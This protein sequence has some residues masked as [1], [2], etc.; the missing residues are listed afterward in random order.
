MKRIKKARRSRFGVIF[1]MDGV[2]IDSEPLQMKVFAVMMRRYGVVI[3]KKEFVSYVGMRAVDNFR[4]IIGKY[5]LTVTPGDLVK[6]KDALYGKVLLG[7]LKAMPGVR[8]LLG[9]L[10]ARGVAMAL[11]SGSSRRDINLVLKG[12]GLRRFFS[13]IVASGDVS[14]GKPHPEGF[15]K[16]AARMGLKQEEIFV[17]EDSAPGVTAARKGGFRT[18]AVPTPFTRSQDLSPAHRIFKDCRAVR[19]Y[20]MSV[21]D[22]ETA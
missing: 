8:A 20:L 9:M 1:D 21:F 22:R 19:T 7:P 18:L 15:L 17:I 10:K 13:H 11:V 2:L 14:K 6:E 4:D 3:P 12:L 5:G 16:A